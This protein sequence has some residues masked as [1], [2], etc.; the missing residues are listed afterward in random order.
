M[1]PATSYP[2]IDYHG[3]TKKITRKA[4]T[5]ALGAYP[6]TIADGSNGFFVYGTADN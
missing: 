1:N 3:S 2:V 4:E 5:C 6:C